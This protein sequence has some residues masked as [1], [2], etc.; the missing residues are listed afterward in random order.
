MRHRIKKSRLGRPSDHRNAMLRNLATSLVI[1]EHV[2]TTISKAKTLQPIMER[3]MGYALKDTPREAI[4]KLDAYFFDQAASKKVLEVLKER[5]QDRKSGFTRIRAT[6]F[7]SGDGST[8]AR[9]E[10]I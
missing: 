9:I 8:T 10:L 7:R 1:E 6:G 3:L 5:Y 2:E 4:R